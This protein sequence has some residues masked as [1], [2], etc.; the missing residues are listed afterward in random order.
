MKSRRSRQ[1]VRIA[2]GQ[3]R[4]REAAAQPKP[5]PRRA[6]AGNL[7]RRQRRQLNVGNAPGQTLAGLA[8]QVDGRRA[9]DQKTALALLPAAPAVDH[10]AQGVEQLRHAVDLVQDHQPVLGGRKEQGRVGEAVA[11]VA[12]FQVQIECISPLANRERL[13]AARCRVG[14]VWADQRAHAQ[15]SA[16]R[17]GMANRPAPAPQI[18]HRGH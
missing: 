9:E 1:T 5:F 2:V 7:Q 16:R 6:V 13:G 8:Q 15:W 4:V 14:G 17:R 10:P 18:A 12:L 11:V 3:V